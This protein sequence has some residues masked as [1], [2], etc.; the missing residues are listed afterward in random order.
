[1]T[2]MEK[3]R[4]QKYTVITDKRVTVCGRVLEHEHTGSAML[5]EIYRA[6]L[7]DWPK[8]FKMD[9]LSKVGYLAS[10]LLLKELGEHRLEGE[11]YTSDRA[12]ALF[13]T[14]AS[15]C[16]DRNYQK[17]IQDI[18]NYYP[19]PAF[20]VYTL[21]NIV[22][23]EIAIRNHYRGETSFYVM[24]GY[25]AGSIAFHLQCA[26]QD[27][28]TESVL[29]GWVDSTDNDDFHCFFTLIDR[30]DASDLE[31]LENELKGIMNNFK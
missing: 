6:Q 9:T 11:E 19:S 28:A 10:E 22:T 18:D 21:P 14:T 24:D 5:T 17:T 30:E 2:D 12:I 26:F 1:M 29:A 23:G 4:N 3:D 7:G 20:F 8:F 27:D 25:D 13:G 15:L 31:G 16:A